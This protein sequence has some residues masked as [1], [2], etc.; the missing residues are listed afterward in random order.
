MTIHDEHPFQSPEPDRDPI[1]RIRGRLAGAV[2]LWTTSNGADKAGLTVSSLLVAAGEPAHVVALLDPD[3][4]FTE[5][6]SITRVA[7]V[8]LLQ[9]H[10]RTLA[11]VFAAQFPAPGGAFRGTDWCETKWGPVLADVTTWAGVRLVDETPT[12][13]GWSQLTNCVIEDVEIGPDD[14]T[15]LHRRGRYH[16]P[17]QR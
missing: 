8:Q 5:M 1:R 15:L 6:L 4:A 14:A 16:R 12:E 3:A 2:T 9:W 10:H 13:V 7:V 17:P 11:E